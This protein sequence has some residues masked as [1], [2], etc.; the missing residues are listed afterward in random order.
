LAKPIRPPG[1]QTRARSD[2]AVFR[3]GENITPNI[4]S[5]ASKLASPKGSLGPQFADELQG[6]ADHRIVPVAH[7][8]RGRPFKTARSVGTFIKAV[9]SFIAI[10]V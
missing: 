1:P 10:T 6:D 3:S 2:A 8:S 4:D 7:A 9:S 5:A